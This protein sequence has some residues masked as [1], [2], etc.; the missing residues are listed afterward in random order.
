MNNPGRLA[1][2]ISK[3]CEELDYELVTDDPD[4]Q[5]WRFE[6]DGEVKTVSIDVD[7]DEITVE[8]LEDGER[9]FFKEYTE[10]DGDVAPAIRRKL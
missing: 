5:D 9:T 1:K 6:E 2:E 10:E 4:W 8:I 7:N 3:V